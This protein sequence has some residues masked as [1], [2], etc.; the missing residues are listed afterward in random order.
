MST[1]VSPS[2]TQCLQSEGNSP[3]HP[4]FRTYPSTFPLEPELALVWSHLSPEKR[5]FIRMACLLDDF[6]LRLSGFSFGNSLPFT[7]PIPL[8]TVFHDRDRFSFPLQPSLSPSRGY[9]FS[10]AKI[11]KW[12]MLSS[13]GFMSFLWKCCALSFTIL[14]ICHFISL[15]L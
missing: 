9:V 1:L 7:P 14:I 11:L 3:I 8:W 5:P 15:I 13:P 10:P 4:L 2:S 6:L 12:N